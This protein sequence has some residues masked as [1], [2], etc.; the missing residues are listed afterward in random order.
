MRS[1]V[2]RSRIGRAPG[3]SVYSPSSFTS[4]SR[5]T[6]AW[7][8]AASKRKARSPRPAA[9]AEPSSTARSIGRSDGG[10]VCSRRSTTAANSVRAAGSA[11]A[12]I[13]PCPAAVHSS[14]NVW[15]TAWTSVPRARADNPVSSTT[16]SSRPSTSRAKYLN[17]HER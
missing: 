10:M 6:S 15:N 14:K 7:G 1:A 12:S 11:A 17:G 9:T 13:A 5:A 2:P 3:P 4:S 16:S 8:C